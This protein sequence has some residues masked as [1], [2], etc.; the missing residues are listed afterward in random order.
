M[1][2]SYV[3]ANGLKTHYIETRG[4]NTATPL[5]ILHGW[6][7]GVD[8]WK[9]IASFLEERGRSV[10]IP[11]LPGFGETPEPQGAW[12]ANEYADFVRSFCE[13]LGLEQF[14]LAGHSFG[15]Q[16]AITFAARY[17]QKLRGLVLIS[18]ARIV[19]HKKLRVR[20][21]RI[22]TKFGNLIFA[23][24]VLSP[25]QPVVRKIWYKLAGEK[26]YYRASPHMR[27]IMAQVQEEVG[28]RLSEIQTPTL[29]LWGE[30][31]HVTPVAD[32]RIIH[33]RILHSK[34][35]IFQGVGHPIHIE[36]PKELAEEIIEFI[37]TMRS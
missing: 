10:F 7:I 34:L 6:G 4:A 22:L 12:G 1:N 17:G 31:D 26:D 36:K 19:T 3:I 28:P 5:I 27:K 35:R 29:I 9:N 15:G 11:D 8:S 24:P 23:I 20:I 37:D 14:S 18:A 2:S 21:F 16:I 13:V 32:A 25:F 30:D 33:S